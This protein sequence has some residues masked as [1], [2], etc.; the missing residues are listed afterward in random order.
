MN[1][2][3]VQNVRLS[4]LLFSSISGSGVNVLRGLC[5]MNNKSKLIVFCGPSGSGKSTLVRRLIGEYPDQL[6]FSVSHTTR[7]PREGE[8]DGVHYHFVDSNKME[9]EIAT[10]KFIESAT[11]SGNMY[12]TSKAAIQNVCEQGKVCVLDIDVQGVKQV[13]N[14]ILRPWYIFIKPP[15][16]KSLEQRLRSR[17]SE[18][19]TSLM[20]R[21]E[22]AIREIAYGEMAGNFDVVIINDDLEHAYGHLKDFV[23]TQI[24]Q[25]DQE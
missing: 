23:E 14:T 2:F 9:D 20:K 17:K 25:T 10:G 19:E 15:S 18:T 11:F 4:H 3:K 5:K 1:I 22:V 8:V 7:K 6:G 21:L 12:G 24:F 16:I 13:K